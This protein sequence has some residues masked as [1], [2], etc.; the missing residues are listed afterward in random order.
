[1][2]KEG[3]HRDYFKCGYCAKHTQLW[4]IEDKWWD[5]SGC[6]GWICPEC[7]LKRLNRHQIHTYEL[8]SLPINPQW[9]WVLRYGVNRL[10]YP[11][12]KSVGTWERRQQ[13]RK[14]ETALC[15]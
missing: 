8:V 5:M 11:R 4:L 14:E 15:E 10:D 9:G 13:Q 6:K 12:P 3:Y 1:M 2:T 7:F